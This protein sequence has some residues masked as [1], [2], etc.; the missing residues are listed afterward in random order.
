MPGAVSNGYGG[1]ATSGAETDVVVSGLAGRLPQSDNIDEFAQQLF[2]GVDLVTADD[3]RW[4]Q[5]GSGG[6]MIAPFT[7]RA[8]IS[9][10]NFA[11]S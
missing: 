8:P 9:L 3:S 1:G 6:G 11:N 2:E 10:T 5:G 7:S 4:P